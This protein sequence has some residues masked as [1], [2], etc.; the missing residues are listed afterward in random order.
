MFVMR[1]LF[2]TGVFQTDFLIN[3]YIGVVS[4]DSIYFGNSGFRNFRGSYALILLTIIFFQMR[5]PEKNYVSEIA[6]SYSNTYKRKIKVTGADSAHKTLRKMWDTNLLNI[7]EQF[8]VLFLNN[9]NEVVG[10]RCLSSGTL[11]AS[12]VD[13]KIL[14][15]LACKS[16]A[17]AIIVAHNHP[18]GKLQP[19]QG[20]INVTNKIKEAGKLL[21][22]K[23][24]DHIILTNN[25]YFSLN[26][27]NLI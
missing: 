12:L 26:D 10:F 4:L 21:D 1:N 7:Q 18:S 8:C 9:A 16:L 15:G 11:T 23:L 27:N 6:V 14:F 20:D 2:I 3:N 24:L 17:S 19:S 13:F 25:D 5:N 22:V